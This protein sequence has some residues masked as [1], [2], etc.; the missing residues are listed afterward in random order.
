MEVTCEETTHGCS[1]T[2]KV[3]ACWAPAT[4]GHSQHCARAV[5]SVQTFD[6]FVAI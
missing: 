4:Y 5:P 3:D 2:H 6:E 1:L